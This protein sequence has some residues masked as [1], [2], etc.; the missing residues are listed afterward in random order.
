MRPRSEAPDLAAGRAGH[1]RVFVHPVWHL[2]PIGFVSLLIVLAIQSWVRDDAR[3]G[4]GM[5]KK[6]VDYR[7]SYAWV[8]EDG[9]VEP[10][11][12]TGELRGPGWRLRDD[13]ERW[14]SYSVGALRSWVRGVRSLHGRA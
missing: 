12:P 9:S 3:F 2:V 1:A 6:H 4:W 13:R 14:T 8:L 10:Y 7:V 11:S 5:F